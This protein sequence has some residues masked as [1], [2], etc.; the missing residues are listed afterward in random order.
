MICPA[1]NV[2]TVSYFPFFLVWV[3][4]CHCLVNIVTVLLSMCG[5]LRAILQSLRPVALEHQCM[6]GAADEIARKILAMAL[7]QGESAHGPAIMW[8]VIV[9]HLLYKIS[10]L[11]TRL[12]KVEK[13]AASSAGDKA[14]FVKRG[15][16]A[17]AATVWQ[18]R[19]RKGTGI[20]SGNAVV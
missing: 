19:C 10:E 14:S 15:D 18:H 12:D 4:T 20:L 6:V 11:S 3:F 1:S 9:R 16:E 2:G 13:V 7:H 17:F 8:S 5:S